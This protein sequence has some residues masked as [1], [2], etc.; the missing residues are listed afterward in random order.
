MRHYTKNT[1]GAFK[2][3]A[4]QGKELSRKFQSS[5][6]KV[7]NVICDEELIEGKKK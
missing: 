2:R 6:E 1:P 3:I 5:V 7:L 4:G